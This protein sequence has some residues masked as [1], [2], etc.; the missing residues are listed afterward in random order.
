MLKE[1]P[2]ST[3][4]SGSSQQQPPQRRPA[5]QQKKEKSK[6]PLVDQLATDLTA[7]AQEYALDLSLIHISSSRSRSPLWN[8][9]TKPAAA[10]SSSI[11]RKR[12][13]AFIHGQY[14]QNY[15]ELGIRD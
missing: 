4:E 11:S 1:S 9:K 7:L 5:Q 12:I 15:V 2:V 10:T 8:R 3:A 6:T 13:V 14:Y